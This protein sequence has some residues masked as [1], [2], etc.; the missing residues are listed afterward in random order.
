MRRKLFGGQTKL[1]C[2]PDHERRL[3]AYLDGELDAGARAGV[4]KHLAACP[5][6]RAECEQLRFASRA[7]AH[8]V[9]P[10][11]RPVGWQAAG[12]GEW[13]R[14]WSVAWLKRFWG[15]KIVV[16]APAVAAITLAVI[17][18]AAA[19]VLFAGRPAQTLTAASPNLSAA[20]AAQ[21][22]VVEVPVER[23]VVRERVVTRTVYRNPS[24]AV[25]GRHAAGASQPTASSVRRAP[26]PMRRATTGDE[27]ITTRASL[28]GFRP[29]A[30]VN[31]RIVKEPEQ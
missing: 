21:I 5:H 12:G 18:M 1:P 19:A 29:A 9:V 22:K 28:T 16:P 6:C 4:E 17:T 2:A 10:E 20:P 13:Q 26:A 27:V 7:M 31:L 15:L 23:E 14:G 30:N 24:R 8:F 3:S 25:Q 11:A